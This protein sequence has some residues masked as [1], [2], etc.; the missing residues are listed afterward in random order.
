MIIVE[1]RLGMLLDPHETKRW[2]KRVR[3]HFKG[4]AVDGEDLQLWGNNLVSLPQALPLWLWF[5]F[6]AFLLCWLASHTVTSKGAEGNPG[7]QLPQ[8]PP[9]CHYQSETS[10]SI[11]RKV[12]TSGL[13][14]PRQSAWPLFAAVVVFVFCE[15]ETGLFVHFGLFVVSVFFFF[16]L[17]WNIKLNK[18]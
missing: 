6:W 8:T 1:R 14:L 3:W 18:D 4:S 15:R 5:W 2:S 16:L 11:K 9:K 17:Q 12:F 10:P 7:V 13:Q